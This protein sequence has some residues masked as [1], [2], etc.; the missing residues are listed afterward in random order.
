MKSIYLAGGCFWGIQRYMDQFNGILNT[1]VGYAN[2]NTQN[3]SYEEVKSQ[4]SG[5]TETV[6]VVY[7]DTIIALRKILEYFYLVIDPTSINK[8]GEDE[9]VSYRTGIYYVEEVELETVNNV[10]KEIQKQYDRP[11]VVGIE[12]L[13]N[14]YPAEEYHQKY[15]EKNPEGYCHID[16][17]LLNLGEISNDIN[18]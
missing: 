7:D 18:K 10:T 12:R 1:T 6:K 9:G 16:G 11:I 17:C 15:L 5:H 2:G 13:D 4:K 14:F 3:P 8:Q